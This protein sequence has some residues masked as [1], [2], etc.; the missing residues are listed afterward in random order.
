MSKKSLITHAFTILVAALALP[1]GAPA[2][3]PPGVPTTQPVD[4]QVDA[5][6]RFPSVAMDGCGR[7]VIGWQE[8]PTGN[9]QV[10]VRI[11]RYGTDGE[12]ILDSPGGTVISAPA[13]HP[14]CFKVPTVNERVSLALGRGE[15]E[16]F[17]EASIYA[18]WTSIRSVFLNAVWQMD[19]EWLFSATP[20][21]LG[22]PPPPYDG[23]DG[24]GEGFGSAGIGQGGTLP[25][26][27]AFIWTSHAGH[28]TDPAAALLGRFSQQPNIVPISR[29]IPA[30]F[31][32]R[33]QPCLSTRSTGESVVVWSEPHFLNDSD[34]PMDIRLVQFSVGG[35]PVGPAGLRGIQANSLDPRVGLSQEPAAVAFGDDGKIVVV[36]RGQNALHCDRDVIF[37]RRFWWGGAPQNDVNPQ[38]AGPE[39][40]V[41]TDP[42]A[43]VAINANPTV[44]L[45]M[46]PNVAGQFV[47][48]WN[49][50]VEGQTQIRAR[51]FDWDENCLSGEFAVTDQVGQIARG[52]QHTAVYG[53]DGQVVVAW[54][55]GGGANPQGVWFTMLP[56]AHASSPIP[57][58]T[59]GDIN[60]DCR[61]NGLDIQPYTNVAVLGLEQAVPPQDRDRVAC[62]LDVD[63]NGT[64]QLQ[65][66]ERDH[67]A[68]VL[69][70]LGIGQGDCNGNC[71]PD[72]LELARDGSTIDCDGNG[73]L[74]ICEHFQKRVYS[75]S[76]DDD[77]LRIIDP[78]SGATSASMPITWMGHAVNGGTGLAW[79]RRFFQPEVDDFYALLKVDGSGAASRELVRLDAHTA[80]VIEHIAT[81]N[82]DF[83][84]LTF[85]PDVGPLWTVTGANSPQ[86]GAFFE[87][88]PDTGATLCLCALGSSGVNEAVAFNLSD[89]LIYHLA[90]AAG[91]NQVFERFYLPKM[92]SCATACD[93]E[94]VPLLDPGPPQASALTGWPEAAVLLAAGPNKLYRMTRYGVVSFVGPLDHRS[95]GLAF[96][97][98]EADCNGNLT[99]DACDMVF[100]H[101][102]PGCADCNGNG[103]LDECD[104]DSGDSEDLNNNG[105][106]D[107]C[108]IT[109]LSDCNEN[110]IEDGYE[111]DCNQSGIPDDCDIT[112]GLSEDCNDNG[113]PDECDLGF[114]ASLDCNEN[115]VPDE[116]DIA[117]GASQDKDENGVP[118]ECEGGEGLIAGGG[119]SLESAVSDADEPWSEEAAWAAFDEWARTED[120]TGL[121]GWEIGYRIKQKL[122][123]LGLWQR[124]VDSGLWIP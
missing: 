27:P 124:L 30:D 13:W 34:A 72:Y 123:E 5:A 16:Q 75:I 45:S 11:R 47:I 73:V 41:S 110:G 83:V 59:P 33:W 50:T 103:A 36:W 8:V 22:P 52:G 90:G 87:I 17:A 112:L 84:G 100:C 55:A 4:V 57:S 102:D 1:A 101:N 99:F 69:L 12:P 80:R 81:L 43:Q 115:L 35:T 7:V 32:E 111:S 49:A 58:C 108:E 109:L 42:R 77:R 29:D 122:I 53:P 20:V 94:V 79:R 85:D 64:L 19:Q 25:T 91:P 119:E 74:D 68:F 114:G 86:P 37:A 51:Y 97:E 24:L 70:L 88:D 39:F 61:I 120:F 28:P 82:D 40:V 48:I 65:E 66:G 67:R 63:R 76:P 10:D 26:R 93:V 3:C 104:I 117:S 46:N 9:P 121:L 62:A 113:W 15:V 95:S 31:A 105:I 89:A 2:Q 118:D 44:A 107:E 71:T 78:G 96:V 92:P 14:N 38:P 56:P 116:C 23:C 98:V 60:G 54:T 6:G 21:P 18:T 106:P